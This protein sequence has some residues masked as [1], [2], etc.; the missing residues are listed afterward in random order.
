VTSGSRGLRATPRSRAAP[1]GPGVARSGAVGGGAWFP[2]YRPAP[3]R[4]LGREDRPRCTACR[5]MQVTL[6]AFAGGQ[7]INDDE[8]EY[9]GFWP[10]DGA[11]L[12]TLC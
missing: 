9:T 12:M 7:M 6:E 8:P 4:R 3:A 1:R 10:L 2:A 11:S 5:V